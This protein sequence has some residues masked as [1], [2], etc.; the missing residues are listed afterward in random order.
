MQKKPAHRAIHLE[1]VLFDIHNAEQILSNIEATEEFQ[2]LRARQKLRYR[3]VLS[4]LRT[5][6][7]DLE[8]DTAQ[9]QLAS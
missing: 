5:L 3:D 6:I 9:E 4:G 2:A 7:Y 1:S 8:Q